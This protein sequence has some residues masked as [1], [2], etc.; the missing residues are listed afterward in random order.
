VSS[1]GP[2]CL[3]CFSLWPFTTGVSC[4]AAVLVIQTPKCWYDHSWRYD[5]S[6]SQGD[7]QLAIQHPIYCISSSKPEINSREDCRAY[8]THKILSPESAAM[9][10]VDLNASDLWSLNTPTAPTESNF[11]NLLSTTS[12]TMSILELKNSEI[13]SM[14]A[15][16][17]SAMSTGSTA[18]I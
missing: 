12:L 5:Q 18:E 9:A 17:V 1:P 2:V 10:A 8:I 7:Y 15:L 6:H 4:Q 14:A 16:T 13:W 11:R 3:Y